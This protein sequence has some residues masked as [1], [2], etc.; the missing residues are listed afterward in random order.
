MKGLTKYFFPSLIAL[1]ALSVS[2]SAAFYSV[3]GLSKLFAGASL[4]V[5]VMATSL[6][7]SKLVVASLLYRYWDELNKVLRA[8]LTGAAFILIIITSLGIYGFL[9]G[10]YQETANKLGIVESQV[11]FLKQKESFYLQDIER[12]DSELERISN[13]IGT[14]S[15]ARAS[16]I[17]VRDTSVA[18]GVRTTIS[19]AELRLAQSR[20]ESEEQT[21]TEVQS[22]RTQ[23]ADSLQSIQIRILELESNNELAAE[24][25]PLKYIS[26]LLS[27]PMDRVVNVL[28]LVIVFVFD[29]LAV[30]L[31][32]AANFAF[33]K[34]S[35]K[36]IQIKEEDLTAEP[37]EK[38][39][40]AFNSFLYDDELDDKTDEEIY[41]NSLEDNLEE[42]VLV[43]SNKQ[44][45]KK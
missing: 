11:S 1:S 31:V 2:A 17:Q 29:P 20:I 26:G 32:I 45:K 14:L 30:S 19:T 5:I 7:I 25:G 6:E 37:N 43:K 34:V 18:G 9:S 41:E 3:F 39:K 27:V 35:N 16:Q 33:E 8:Y 22:K 23:S 4:Q 42:E 10:A 15:Q 28:L 40:K 13:T 44:I 12:Y 21:R 38:L 24:L 36:T